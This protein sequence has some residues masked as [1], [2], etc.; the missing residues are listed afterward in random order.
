MTALLVIAGQEVRAGIRNRWVI[1]TTVILAALALSLVLLGSTPTGTIGASPLTV[2]VVSL[3]SLTIFLVPLIA[4]LL[5]FDS[6]VGED[7]RGTLLLLLAYPVSRGQI[8][9][10]KFVGQITILALATVV[11]YGV[12]GA[13]L[14]FGSAG[15]AENWP[16]FAVLI[17]TSILLGAV[18]IALGVLVS[19]VV[20]ER[21]TAAGLAV[22]LWLLLVLVYDLALVGLLVADQGKSVTE[23]MLN[24]LLLLNPTDIYRLINLTGHDAVAQVAGMA[25]MQANLSL[26]A[27]YAALL[28]WVALPL[29]AGILIFN[30]RR[31]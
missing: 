25:A 19:I 14:Y 13:V 9:L 7:E 4:L 16:D 17:G 10:G 8:V 3:A 27:L 30:K 29:A 26:S 31:A 5:S 23:S 24:G 12:A 22:G 2:V 15:D 1:M 21:A 6:I 20:R 28:A 18:F 11:G